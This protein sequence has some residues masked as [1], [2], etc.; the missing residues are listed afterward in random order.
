MSA[1]SVRHRIPKHLE[2]AA[3]AAEIAV[4]AG[5]LIRGYFERGVATEYKGDVDLVTEADRASEARSSSRRA[6]WR[7]SSRTAEMESARRFLRIVSRNT[8]DSW[9]SV[10]RFLALRSTLL[11]VRLGIPPIILLETF[12]QHQ[13][14]RR[15]VAQS[16][17]V[18]VSL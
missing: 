1:T 10:K 15:Y 7:I 17:T 11:P 4:E 13:N 18:P 6:A 8:T 9:E 16:E 14:R 3:S 2:I 12:A 5:A